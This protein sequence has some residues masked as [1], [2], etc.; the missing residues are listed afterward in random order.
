MTLPTGFPVARFRRALLTWY[1]RTA[2]DLPWR[3]TR[4]PYAIW[5]S[6]IMLQQTRVQTVVSYYERFLAA[7]PNATALAAAP[8][9]DVLHAWQGLGYYSRARHLHAAA[10]IIA[11]E[12]RGQFP[13]TVAEWAELPG[14]GPYTA[15]ALA[16]ITAGVPVATV[17]GNIQRVLARVFAEEGRIEAQATRQRLWALANEL[18]ARR[19][20]GDFNQALMEL[21]A[22]LCRPRAP[23]CEH[24][25]VRRA[26]RGYALRR[27]DELPRRAQKRAVPRVDAVAALVVRDTRVLLVRRPDHGLLAG[28]WTLPATTLTNGKTPAA[29]LQAYARDE[30]GLLLQ[31]AACLATVRHDFT[32]RRLFVQILAAQ[33]ESLPRARRAARSTAAAARGCARRV[34]HAWVLPSDLSR[35]PRATL[36][37]KLLEAVSGHL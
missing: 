3:R 12:R 30:L 28:L 22:R 25:P 33:A 14:I 11:G 6:E 9:A 16:S 23:D 13:S 36:D 20:A 7:F 18:L 34:E 1:R 4:D 10:Q 2:R 19:T 15:A 21:G 8:L 29:A 17:D 37:R 32:H 5:V 27:V 31:P 26:C 35:Y 24:C